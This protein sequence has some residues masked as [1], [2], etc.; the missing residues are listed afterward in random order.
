MNEKKVVFGN[1]ARE[2]LLVGINTLYDA[3]SVTMG[4]MG[5]NVIIKRSH[6]VPAHITKDGVTVVKDITLIDPI[7]DLGAQI[8]KEA[9]LK[10]ADKA[11]DGTTTATVLA[12]TIISKGILNARNGINTVKMK[13]GIEIASDIAVDYIKNRAKIVEAND[14][15]IC[16]IATISANNDIEIGKLIAEGMAKVKADGT[17][18][19]ENS[20]TSETTIE[21]VEGMKLDKGYVSP[22]FMTDTE[23]LTATM[24]E[25][26]I[27]CC[28]TVVS[29]MNSIVPIL[30][31]VSRASG[32]IVIFAN[33]IEG[34]A[35]SAMILNKVKGLLKVVAIKAPNHGDVRSEIL[36]D[37]ATVCSGNVIDPKS[38]VEFA[39]VVLGRA[40][41]VIVT[42]DNTTII[43]G[44]GKSE[45]IKARQEQIR[46]LVDTCKYDH[47]KSLHKT[48]L[49][50]I[51]GGIAIMYVGAATEI[52]MKEKKDRIDDALHATKAALEEGIIPGGGLVYMQ[53]A[54]AI[55]NA[56]SC[57]LDTDEDLVMGMK[58]VAQ[59]LHVPFNVIMKNAGETPE[60]ILKNILDA[61]DKN[62]GYDAKSGKYGDMFEFG[63]IDPAKVARIAIETATSIACTFL[64]TEC[65]IAP[66]RINP[67]TGV[68]IN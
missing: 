46:S 16:N 36:K 64:T 52:E 67:V 2:K 45:D 26:F 5:K 61:H 55:R 51:S 3:V 19:L 40:T 34:D 9:A 20:K 33:E 43:G 8:V 49:A 31:M 68:T 18:A 22:Y 4:P 30:E 15:E 66:E 62:Y 53:A 58:I 48:R 17:I 21:V 60:V 44:A 13:K 12:T 42:R 39:N 10:T 54:D 6:A 25:P 63:I 1:E 27:L 11:G 29:D 59:S 50:R 23:K 24:D 56:I 57:S 14:T 37:I 65:V 28:D 35:L 41:K 7:E 32:S 47:E 38:G